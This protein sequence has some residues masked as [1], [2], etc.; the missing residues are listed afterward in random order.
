MD[1][2]ELRISNNICQC[3]RVVSVGYGVV[4]GPACLSSDKARSAGETKQRRTTLLLCV[5]L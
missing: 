2:Q 5:H 3:F 1:A 4:I